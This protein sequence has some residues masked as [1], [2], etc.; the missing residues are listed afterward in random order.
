MTDNTDSIRELPAETVERIA[1]GEVITRP[2]RVVAELV[3]NALDAGAD[4]VEIA[5]AGD[6]T[7]RI[8]VADDGHGLDRE[9]AVRAVEPHTTSKI[10]DAEDLQRADTLGF[11]GEALASVADAAREVEL[12]TNDRDG[13]GDGGTGDGGT[14]GTHVVVRGDSE[15]RTVSDAGRARGTTVTVSGLFADR[16]ARRESLA[17][18]ASEFGRI[19]A[20]VGRYALLSADVAFTLDHDGREVLSTPGTGV[21]DALLSVYDR[22]TAG[23]STGFDHETT[24]EFTERSDTLSIS[25]HLVYPSITRSDRSHV[26]VAVNGRPVRNDDL[27]RAVAAGYGTLLSDGAEPVAVVEISVPPTT[28]DANVHPAKQRVAL[29]DSEGICDAVTTAV[30]ET[31]TTVDLRRSGEVAMDLDS[32]LEPVATTDSDFADATVIGQYRELYLLCESDEDLLVVDQHAAHERV[33]FERLREAV[34]DGD[35]PSVPTRE[36]DPPATVS[37]DP[38]TAAVVADET[39]TLQE[40]GFDV[41]SFGGTTYRV[42]RVP[43]P[44]GRTADPESLRETARQLADGTVADP[45]E[46]IL[47]ELACHPSLKAGDDLGGETAEALLDRLGR[48][49]QPYACP[50][51]RPT[52][53]TID[54]ATLVSGFDRENTRL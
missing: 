16:R 18:A 44:L 41:S 25:G 52:V 29:A 30:R 19:S 8:T 17:S 13:T 34:T 24:A 9:D 20:L 14:G 42:E 1:A 6:G 31:L 4:S 48:C 46:E 53:L 43:A 23:Q 37:L 7:D 51:G 49:E 33:N 47:A 10:R 28:V 21:T 39:E 22:E 32:S 36:I 35:Q 45:R 27:R 54:E 11:R 15:D 40:I 50:H 3:E 12:V 2:V 38:E 5:V 26:H